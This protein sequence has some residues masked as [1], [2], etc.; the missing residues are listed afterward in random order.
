MDC[1]GDCFAAGKPRVLFWRGRNNGGGVNSVA[2]WETADPVVHCLDRGGGGVEVPKFPWP[3]AALRPRGDGGAEAILVA[4]GDSAAVEDAVVDVAAVE[5]VALEAAAVE[6]AA[7]VVVVA[8]AGVAVAEVLAT[9]AATRGRGSS[10]PRQP[11]PVSA[12]TP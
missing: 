11:C 5:A 10:C 8:A 12:G 2:P 6:A 1:G 9:F 7:A 3:Q 4:M